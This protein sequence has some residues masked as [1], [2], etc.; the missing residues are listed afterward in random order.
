MARAVIVVLI[1]CAAAFC[2]FA[3]VDVDLQDTELAD[4]QDLQ[5]DE[6]LTPDQFLRVNATE[7]L[8]KIEEILGVIEDKIAEATARVE[9]SVEAALQGIEDAA[10][11]S[12]AK[13]NASV[14]EWVEKANRAGVNVQLCLDSQN[15][16]LADVCADLKK[17][18][19]RCVSSSIADI[20]VAV[21]NVQKAGPEARALL[22]NAGNA[23]VECTQKPNVI[24]VGICLGTSLVPI[25]IKA[26]ALMAKTVWRSG[27][28]AAKTAGLGPLSSLCASR[29]TV[30][31]SAEATKIVNTTVCCIKA[32]LGQKC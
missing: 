3:D 22:E 19:R 8:E 20:R 26:T 27:V 18:A 30:A 2:A 24:Q 5:S 7:I 29:A 9:A 23:V 14:Q 16:T 32:A 15:R 4:L 1:A 11:D 17:D 25:H 13:W 10:L 6:I 12:A 31:R 28:V 21:A